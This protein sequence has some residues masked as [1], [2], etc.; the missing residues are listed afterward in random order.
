MHKISHTTVIA[1]LGALAACSNDTR[2]TRPP[3]VSAR[4][5]V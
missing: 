2:I 3:E 1:A 4:R 5:D